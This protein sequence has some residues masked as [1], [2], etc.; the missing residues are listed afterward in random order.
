MTKPKEHS[1][2][3][4]GVLTLFL[5]DRLSFSSS[6]PTA[7]SLRT[8]LHI[9]VW[10]HNV[11]IL[12]FQHTGRPSCEYQ[13]KIH[14][15]P[16]TSDPYYF[17]WEFALPN[18]SGLGSGYPTCVQNKPLNTST[19][20]SSST[21]CSAEC[22]SNS[23][24]IS[25]SQ[26]VFSLSDMASSLVT[27]FHL[28]C[29]DQWLLPF[30]QSVFFAGVLVGAAVYGHLGDLLGRRTAFLIGMV[31]TSVAGIAAAYSPDLVCFCV[32]MFITA[33]GQVRELSKV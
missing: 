21:S 5:I 16:I 28:V 8:L 24:T 25:C 4:C 15:L 23:S 26:H 3:I 30:S 11:M 27:E 33:M 7:F 14:P 17:N 29:E 2:E 22:F 9:V 31:Q 32:L 18:S 13:L 20:S 12:C 1:R 19:C 10:F 6:L